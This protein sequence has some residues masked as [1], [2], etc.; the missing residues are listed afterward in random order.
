[1]AG[2]AVPPV[3]ATIDRQ[4]A[5]GMVVWQ[6]FLR[7]HSELDGKAGRDHS[8]PSKAATAMQDDL[9]SRSELP[10]QDMTGVRPKRLEN[11]RPGPVRQGS[12]GGATQVPP[13]RLCHPG[14]AR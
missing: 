13:V 10:S 11:D 2:P 14:Q 4:S 3:Q 5:R 1:M 12:E 6:R 7:G 8:R 9:L